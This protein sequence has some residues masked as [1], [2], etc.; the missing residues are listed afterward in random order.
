MVEPLTPPPHFGVVLVTPAGGLSTAEVYAEADR[1]GALREPAELD[2]V[3]AELRS[4]A[5]PGASPLDYAELLV[6]DLTRAA[7]ELRPAISAALEALR[8]A[9]AR[10]ALLT[11]SGPTVFGLFDDIAAA[12]RA[13]GALPPRY[14]GAIVAAPESGR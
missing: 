14:A 8:D 1:L 12:D 7:T 9:G 11:G 6:N 5:A 10:V 2:R 4:A 13:A 3:D